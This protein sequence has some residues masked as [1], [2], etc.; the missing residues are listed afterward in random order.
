M[1]LAGVLKQHFTFLFYILFTH[2]SLQ[3]K[4]QFQR[5][6]AGLT[7]FVTTSDI[8]EKVLTQNVTS[9]M[10]DDWLFFKRA[11]KHSGKSKT[12]FKDKTNFHFRAKKL[13]NEVRKV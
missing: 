10:E 7:G 12:M 2:P 6:G 3:T 13:V 1:R 8:E 9:Y 4:F 5:M 11:I